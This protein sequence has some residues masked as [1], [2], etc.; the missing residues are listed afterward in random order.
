MIQHLRLAK[1]VVLHQKGAC[2]RQ[3]STVCFRA[4]LRF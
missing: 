1:S 4:I 2:Q 3:S